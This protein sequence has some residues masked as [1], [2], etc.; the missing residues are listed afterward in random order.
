M[1]YSNTESPSTR[2]SHQS[3]ASPNGYTPRMQTQSTRASTTTHKTGQSPAYTPISTAPTSRQPE[4]AQS[5]KRQ[6]RQHSSTNQRR[7]EH[8]PV[9][10]WLFREMRQNDLS[11]HPPKNKAHCQTKQH[12]S[13]LAQQTRMFT[14]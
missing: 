12:E 4:Y 2:K 5:K 14:A 1:E 7:Q 13:I 10:E 8:S 9:R 6:I 11:R 3:Q